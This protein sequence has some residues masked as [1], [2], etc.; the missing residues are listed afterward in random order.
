MSS[1]CPH[2]TEPRHPLGPSIGRLLETNPEAVSDRQLLCYVRYLDL[3]ID[4]RKAALVVRMVRLQCRPGI[5][6]VIDDVLGS[7]A[8]RTALALVFERMFD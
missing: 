8:N 4:E 3:A 7:S 6:G 2:I 5:A 1:I